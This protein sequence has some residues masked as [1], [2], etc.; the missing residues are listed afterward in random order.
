M[1]IYALHLEFIRDC[2]TGN[3]VGVRNY[4]FLCLS[5]VIRCN[6]YAYKIDQQH[7]NNTPHIEAILSICGVLAKNSCRYSDPP[8]SDLIWSTIL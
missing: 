5:I 1:K 2:K 7:D 6:E 8:H 4:V 3:S